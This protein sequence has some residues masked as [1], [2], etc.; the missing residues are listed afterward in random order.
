MGKKGEG[1]REHGRGWERT[2]EKVG[3]NRG[4]VGENTGVG[5]I[6][7]RRGRDRTQEHRRGSGI[8]QEREDNTGD[9]G[10]EHSRGWER[11]QKREGEFTAEGGRA[12]EM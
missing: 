3:E 1:G 10:R 11:T 8:T 6:K 7:H 9:G 2:K 12:Q 4:G 5:G